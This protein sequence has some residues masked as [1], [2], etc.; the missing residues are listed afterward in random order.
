MSVLAAGCGST[1]NTSTT[2][3]VQ[4]IKVRN[5]PSF[6]SAQVACSAVP[7]AALARTLG[8]SSL[9]PGAIAKTY[10]EKHAPL[11]ARQDVA[12]GCLAGLTK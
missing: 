4:R 6:N 1:G 2:H 7:R 9:D 8:L 10:A 12:R 11:A 5:T 3:T